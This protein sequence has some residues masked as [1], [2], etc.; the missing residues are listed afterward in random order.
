MGIGFVKEQDMS[1]ASALPLQPEQVIGLH[2]RLMAHA[3][4]LANDD[5][6]AKMLSSQAAGTGVLPAGLGL[7]LVAFSC[8]LLRHFPQSG[9]L[10]ELDSAQWP[11]EARVAERQDLIDLMVEHRAGLDDSEAWMAHIVA[12]ACMGGNHLWQDLGL[13]N[14]TD[15]SRLMT[16]N[17]PSLAAKNVRDMKWKKFLYKQL[18]QREGVYVCRSPSCEVC[19]DYANCFGPE[20]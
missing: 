6:F 15:L 14:R 10:F 5:L 3:A 13:W 2:D 8:L 1:H 9:P 19:V 7:P 11:D 4:G 18:C 12:A 17:F 20:E 16:E